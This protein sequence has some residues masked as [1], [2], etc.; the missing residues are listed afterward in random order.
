MRK[1]INI[2]GTAYEVY[3]DDLNNRDLAVNDGFCLI[4]DKEIV[5][6][7]PEYMDGL[8]ARSRKERW[9][10]VLRHEL[11]HAAAQESGVKYGDDEALVDWIA[12]IVPIIN[13]AVESLKSEG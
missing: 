8:S 11:I 3:S 1:K 12:H 9:N 4:Y 2:L 6:R 5:I 7:Q 13:N 10:H